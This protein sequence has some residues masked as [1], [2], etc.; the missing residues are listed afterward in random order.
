MESSDVFVVT[1]GEYDD[2]RIMA[3]FDSTA[4]ATVFA[5][6]V[7]GEVKVFKLNTAVPEIYSHFCVL[8]LD[9]GDSIME[10]RATPRLKQ[11]TGTYDQHRT[12]WAYGTT[13]E[14]AKETAENT[15]RRFLGEI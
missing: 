11:E 14:A 5:S 12:V 8:N 10:E 13:K 3:V 1:T 6:E 9:T 4:N 15:R 7:G 2:Y